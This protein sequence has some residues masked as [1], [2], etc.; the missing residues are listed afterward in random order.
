MREGRAK[1]IGAKPR[2]LVLTGP[3]ASGK[4]SLA[5]RLALDLG[6]EIVNADSMQVYRGM[7]I[8][9][10]KPTPEERRGIPHHLMDVV[11]P[12]E[13]FDAARYRD[14]AL[15]AVRDIL[16]RGRACL[17]VG[18]T[19]LY[20]RILLGGLF[21]GAQAASAVRRALR[22]EAESEGALFLHRRLSRM[23]PETARRVHPHD[24][25][26]VIRALE[27]LHVTGRRPSELMRE[28]GFRDRP[29]DALKFCLD[30]PRQ[31]LYLRI[32]ARSE[33]MLRSGLIEE[34]QG[35][36]DAGF[37]PGLKPM[38]AIGYRHVLQYLDAGISL[39]ETLRRLQRDTRRYAKR[40]MTWFRAEENLK[41]VS[42]QA[43]DIILRSAEDFLAEAS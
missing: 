8:G 37:A 6:A 2:I 17:V 31:D 12:D 40:Q 18:G 3:T 4:T 30:I 34:T 11:D 27:V 21:P 15:V 5:V 43:Y 20:L 13:P 29:L 14:L 23:D 19:G 36:L 9:T 1:R 26:R 10:A 35:L 38:K 32:D 22:E 42:P 16:S 24:A 7:D 28:H 41:W 25:Y 33:E 39:E